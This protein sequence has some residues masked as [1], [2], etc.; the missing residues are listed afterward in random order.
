MAVVGLYVAR[1][2]RVM[3]D[4]FNVIHAGSPADD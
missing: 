2:Q 4:A 3:P 1:E